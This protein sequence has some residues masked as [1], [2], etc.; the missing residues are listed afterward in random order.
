MKLV[1]ESE[2]QLFQLS[3]IHTHEATIHSILYTA[4]AFEELLL[5]R[6]FSTITRFHLGKTLYHLQQSLND[7]HAATTLATIAVITNLTSAASACGDMETTIKHMDGLC[8]ILE[9]RGGIAPVDTASMIELKC[10]RYLIYRIFRSAHLVI[11]V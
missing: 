6:P 10:Q 5:R 2:A 9:L 11:L 3:D 8:R 4:Q 7:V 1:H